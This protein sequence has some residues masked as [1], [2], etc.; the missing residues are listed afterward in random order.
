MDRT[1]YQ[2]LALLQENARMT[3]RQISQKVNLS[4]PSVTER[5]HRMEE[6]GVIL[7]Y[8]AAIDPLKIQKNLQ[9]FISVDITPERYQSFITFCAQAPEIIEH[10]R[11]IGSHSAMLLAA[12]HDSRELEMLIDRLKKFGT[13]NT[14]VILS[15]FFRNKPFQT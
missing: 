9:V 14:S 10:H 15:T 5:I 8:H 11:I 13:T 2:I 12:L 1:D 7:G 4:A 3:I 6:Q